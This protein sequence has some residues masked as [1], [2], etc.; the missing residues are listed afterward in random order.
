MIKFDEPPIQRPNSL[1]RNRR[2]DRNNPQSPTG[3]G[4]S[5]N[6]SGDNNLLYPFTLH[7]T[8]RLGGQCVLYAESASVRA[9]WQKKL[10]ETLGLR[11][12]VMESNKVFEMETLSQETFLV[13]SVPGT[14]VVPSWSDTTTFGGKVTCSIPFSA[15]TRLSLA[16]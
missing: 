7:H 14:Q 12:V 9:E 5:R 2:N 15:S 3:V 6:D 16:F 8:G 1:L 4:H 13:P 11:K 10:E